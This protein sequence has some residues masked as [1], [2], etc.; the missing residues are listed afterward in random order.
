M[1]GSSQAGG[2]EPDEERVLAV[3]GKYISR[4]TAKG[5]LENARRELGLMEKKGGVISYA[6]LIEKLVSGVRLFRP[7]V[8]QTMLT[9]ELQ[10][11]AGPGEVSAGAISLAVLVE[12]DLA[13]VRAAARDLCHKLGVASLPLQKVATI[14]SELAR[15]MVNYA[16]GG[17]ISL[18]PSVGERRTV[19]IR[20]V[21]AG[22]GIPNLTEI[23]EGRYRSRTGLGLGILGVK[24]LAARFQIETGPRGTT[25]EAEVNL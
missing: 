16:G 9:A 11:L 4:I 10:S 15:N 13:W 25:I 21:D 17:Q 14:V 1:R 24:R 19:V 12:G 6:M 8:L 22:G 7:N 20:A 5:L 3:L 23:M 18:V 2:S